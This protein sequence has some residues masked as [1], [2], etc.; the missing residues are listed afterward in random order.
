MSVILTNLLIAITNSNLWGQA[1]RKSRM[2][3]L[4]R[5]CGLRLVCLSMRWIP[6]CMMGT[7]CMDRAQV[8]VV[9]SLRN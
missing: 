4:S 8:D 6:T 7:L 9:S 5:E 1:L 2:L 3:P